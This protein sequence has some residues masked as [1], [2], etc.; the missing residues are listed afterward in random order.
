M[1]NPIRAWRTQKQIKHLLGKSGRIITWTTIYVT[2][3]DFKKQAPY[4]VVLVEYIDGERA[5]GPLVNYGDCD[6]SI[7]KEVFGVLRIVRKGNSDEIIEY[8]IKFKPKA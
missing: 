2:T 4:P 3:P 1:I 7:G 6:L 8:G 5:Y